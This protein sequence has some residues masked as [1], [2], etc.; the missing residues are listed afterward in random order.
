MPNLLDL[1]RRA[2]VDHV[3]ARGSYG[4]RRADPVD[5]AREPDV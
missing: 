3:A 2:E 5:P 1:V 4:N